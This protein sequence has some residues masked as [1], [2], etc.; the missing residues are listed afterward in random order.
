M[1]F[2]AGL[3]IILT[4]HTGV[5]MA[6]VLVYFYGQSLGTYIYMRAA[7]WLTII[8]PVLRLVNNIDTG[9]VSITGKFTFFTIKFY[10]YH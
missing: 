6:M 1:A 10:S 5:N 8:V 7:K 4:K 2:T 9:T 3:S